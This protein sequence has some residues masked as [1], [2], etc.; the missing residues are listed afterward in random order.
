MKKNIFY[1]PTYMFIY[2]YNLYVLFLSYIF[3]AYLD[4]I[5]KTKIISYV[6]KLSIL[7]CWIAVKTDKTT[8]ALSEVY[9]F[10]SLI[11][12]V[13]ITSIKTANIHIALYRNNNY[14]HD[15]VVYVSNYN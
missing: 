6:V 13:Y 9:L 3:I 2:F 11:P 7:L 8:V 15:S 1:I 12:C 4:F 5:L 10:V 14:N